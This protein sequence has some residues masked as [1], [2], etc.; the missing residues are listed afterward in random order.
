MTRFKLALAALL[1]SPMVAQADVITWHLADFQFDDGGSASGF[2]DWDTDTGSAINWEIMVSG[3]NTTDFPEM[4]Y[5]DESGGFISFFS[6]VATLIFCDTVGCQNPRRDFR[7]GVADFGLLDIGVSNLA[8]AAGSFVGPTGYVEC[9]NC[10]PVRFGVEGAYLSVPEPGTL[11]LLGMGLFG[12]GLA[13]RRRR[14]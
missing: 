13:G 5:T 6:E 10:T 14:A 9:F 7:I 3:G 2:F 12:M 8:L 11:A 4:T 1:L